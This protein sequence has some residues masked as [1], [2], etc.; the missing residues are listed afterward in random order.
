MINI[1]LWRVGNSV[2][3]T[4]KVDNTI[5]EAWEGKGDFTTIRGRFA[6]ICIEVDLMKKLV[7]K[8]QI[9]MRKYKVEYEGL[10][11]IYFEIWTS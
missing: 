4:L 1:F 3:R 7:P 2:G 9:R 5:R 11:L 8:T 10:N 6:R